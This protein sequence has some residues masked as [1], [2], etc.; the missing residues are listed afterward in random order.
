MENSM[1]AQIDTSEV[2]SEDLASHVAICSLRYQNLEDKLQNVDTK[3]E[4]KFSSVEASIADMKADIKSLA[5]ASTKTTE[6]SQ[7]RLIGIGKWVIGGL[8]T[9]CGFLL[10]HILFH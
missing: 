5:T 4:D 7:D 6:Q 1:A 8:L 2:E 9:V 10:M 3:L